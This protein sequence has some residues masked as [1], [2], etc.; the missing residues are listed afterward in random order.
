MDKGC[1]NYLIIGYLTAFS[2]V[3]VLLV[4]WITVHVYLT[5]LLITANNS[6][7]YE[8]VSGRSI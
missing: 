5:I 6:E 8:L 2:N 1:I 3:Y 7:I 4:I